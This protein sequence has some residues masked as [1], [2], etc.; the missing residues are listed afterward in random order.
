[1]T[2]LGK[3]TGKNPTVYPDAG[4][5]ELLREFAARDYKVGAEIGVWRGGFAEAMCQAI[6][7]LRLLCVDAWGTDPSYHEAKTDA[8]WDKVKRQAEDRLR[9]YGCV[10]DARPSVRAALDVPDQSL[11]F[12]YIDANHGL[13][14][15]ISDLVTWSQ[16]VRPGGMVAGHDYK[17]FPRRPTILVKEAVDAFVEKHRIADWAVLAREDCPSFCWVVQ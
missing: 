11:D 13:H 3:G 9:P 12:V 10:I 1:M 4:R 17:P 5:T 2:H 8:S 15:V 7:G 6:P 14:A 16:K